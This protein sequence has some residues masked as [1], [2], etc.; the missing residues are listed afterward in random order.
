MIGLRVRNK[1]IKNLR[2]RI[3]RQ[4]SDKTVMVLYDGCKLE[5]RAWLSDLHIER[6]AKR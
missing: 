1:V 4:E 6:H 2:G 5:R 3:I